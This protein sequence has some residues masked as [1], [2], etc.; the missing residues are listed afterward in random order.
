[1]S[2]AP[3]PG[4]NILKMARHITGW[5]GRVAK[6][7]IFLLAGL[8][9]SAQAQPTLTPEVPREFYLPC[10]TNQ[11]PE[12]YGTFAI[13][14]ASLYQQGTNG[15]PVAES[16]LTPS[17]IPPVVGGFDGRS[18]EAYS[19]S[20][21]VVTA[22]TTNVWRLIPTA[23][24]GF[25]TAQQFSSE[26]ELAE[27][28]PAGTWTARYQVTVSDAPPFQGFFFFHVS[29]N[30]PPVP[31]L[32]NLAAALSVDPAVPFR[33]EWEP[34]TTAQTND[35]VALHMVDEDGSTVFSAATDCTGELPLPLRAASAEI[36]AG[37]LQPGTTYTG[38]LAFAGSIV[39]AQDDRSLQ[40]L[41]GIDARITRFTLRTAGTAPL[42]TADLLDLRISGTNLLMQVRGTPRTSYRVQSTTN[43]V[44]WITVRFV[45]LPISGLL[46]ISIPLPGDGIPRFYRAVDASV[47]EPGEAAVFTFNRFDQ[48][49][50]IQL[51]GTPGAS[52]R[53]ESSTNLS[54]WLPIRPQPFVIPPR[55]Q[56]VPITVLT[57]S[58]LRQ[59]FLR[60]VS[61]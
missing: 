19:L 4:D 37:R 33:L 32:T 43:F 18:P 3:D 49:M 12:G 57:T 21:V 28:M 53:V 56:S 44:D 60:A 30:P 24:G 7:R 15:V 35:R 31:Q 38:F 25:G 39:A 46:S 10:F 50:L 14:K 6:G 41:R 8:C 23:S 48:F 1:M 16:P 20:N 17:S 36:P 54:H 29:S 47:V 55:G 13:L 40:V 27:A 11:V 22:P 45:N 9:V 5:V 58:G 2:R 59:Q 26:Q 61:P 52:Y 42:D 51:M 34:W